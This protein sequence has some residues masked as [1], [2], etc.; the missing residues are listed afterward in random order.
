[1]ESKWESYESQFGKERE[2]LLDLSRQRVSLAFVGSILSQLMSSL[3]PYLYW[4]HAN[5]GHQGVSEGFGNCGSDQECVV[6][7]TCVKTMM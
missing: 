1:M 5:A 6:L 3:P 4:H 7:E 2:R